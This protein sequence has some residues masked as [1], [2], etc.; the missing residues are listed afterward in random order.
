M[1]KD[2]RKIQNG[3]LIFS[4]LKNQPKQD[5]QALCVVYINIIIVIIIIITVIHCNTMQYSRRLERA[6]WVN[7]LSKPKTKT[8]NIRVSFIGMR[9][10]HN[11][12]DTKASYSYLNR[13]SRIPGGR[14]WPQVIRNVDSSFS[15]LGNILLELFQGKAFNSRLSALR[16]RGL[17]LKNCNKFIIITVI[18]C[19]TM[20]Y[21]R[22]L[23]NGFMGYRTMLKLSG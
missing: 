6:L 21:S 13:M 8:K 9:Q 12:L 5:N 16:Q 15:Q 22:G 19:N 20:Q 3:I 7:I 18:H 14:E 4:C 2:Y 11:F 17:I 23:Q 10:L 1:G